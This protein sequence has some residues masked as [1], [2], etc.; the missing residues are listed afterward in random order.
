MAAHTRVGGWKEKAFFFFYQK[1][2]KISLQVI[3]SELNVDGTFHPS[4]SD[5]GRTGICCPGITK[6]EW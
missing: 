1:L 4:S 5:G 6:E 3:G 2:K